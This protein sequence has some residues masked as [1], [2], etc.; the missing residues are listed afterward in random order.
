MA[1]AEPHTAVGTRGGLPRRGKTAKRRTDWVPVPEWFALLQAEAK[2]D[3][4]GRCSKL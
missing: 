1:E 3:R 2:R 4:V